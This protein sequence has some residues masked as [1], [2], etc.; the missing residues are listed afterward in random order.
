M[1]SR[2]PTLP[3][4][5]D[6]DHRRE[7][8]LFSQ[9]QPLTPQYHTSGGIPSGPMPTNIPLGIPLRRAGAQASASLVNAPGIVLSPHTLENPRTYPQSPHPTVLRPVISRENLHALNFAKF[10]IS[11]AHQ[12]L[13]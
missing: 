9:I 6:L 11:H 13:T 12:G 3:G 10:N 2:Y 8:R 1:S 4:T 5:G 7:S